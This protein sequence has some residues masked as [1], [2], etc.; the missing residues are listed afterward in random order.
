MIVN[1]GAIVKDGYADHQRRQ[2]EPLSCLIFMDS[3]QVHNTDD[4]ANNIRK[5]LNDLWEKRRK[6]QPTTEQPKDR[7]LDLT[8]NSCNFRMFRPEGKYV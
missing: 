3:L 6:Q 4:I 7:E 2:D 5:W 1:P 8:F